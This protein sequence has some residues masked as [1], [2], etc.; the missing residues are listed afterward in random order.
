MP[1]MNGA[2][3]VREIWKIDPNM[4]VVIVTAFSDILPDEIVGIVG[5]EDIFYLRKPF[6]PQEIRQFARALC[7]QWDFDREREEAL[8]VTEGRKRESLVCMAGAVAH[9]LNNL[10]SRGNG[11]SGTAHGRRSGGTAKRAVFWSTP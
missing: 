4:K 10:L 6:N 1:G 7:S 8:L 5:R 11:K 9:H 3:T 2:E